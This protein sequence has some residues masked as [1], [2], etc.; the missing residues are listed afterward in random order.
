M[1]DAEQRTVNW[2]LVVLAVVAVFAAIVLAR[3]FLMPVFLAFLVSVTVSPI[4]RQ[5]AKRGVQ[6]R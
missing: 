3:T 1:S 2:P 5:L 4:R 6:S